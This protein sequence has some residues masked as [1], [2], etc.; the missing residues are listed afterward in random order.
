MQRHPQRRVGSGRATIPKK[1][2][3]Q[4]RLHWPW[5]PM[6]A[7][8][9]H[10]THGQWWE[11]RHRDT[12]VQRNKLDFGPNCEGN[13]AVRSSSGCSCD[14]ALHTCRTNWR[15]CSLH[16]FR[17]CLHFAP[18]PRGAS[19]PPTPWDKCRDAAR[20][21]AVAGQ[22]TRRC[23]EVSGAE[24]RHSH[25]GWATAPIEWRKAPQRTPPAIR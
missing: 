13:V 8:G 23:S 6:R 20:M 12:C 17:G 3:S 5:R 18:P 7:V 4:V 21:G 19:P 9:G 1:R 24:R 11:H 16:V 25:S 2:C 14:A 15:S 10:P 22:W